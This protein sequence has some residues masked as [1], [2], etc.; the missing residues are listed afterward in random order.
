M[1]I[2]DNAD[3]IA[4]LKSNS[5]IIFIVIGSKEDELAKAN[6]KPFTINVNRG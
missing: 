4:Q 3:A 5:R 2:E 6:S 1:I